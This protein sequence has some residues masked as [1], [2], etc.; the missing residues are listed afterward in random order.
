VS[1]KGVSEGLFVL[2]NEPANHTPGY[3]GM[4]CANCSATITEAVEGPRRGQRATVN[5]ATDEG[6]VEYD[7]DVVSL[8]EIYDAVEDAGYEPQRGPP[9]PSPSRT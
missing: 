6:S 7:P 4:S 8:T 2:Y 1:V 3:Q 9:S 5:Y